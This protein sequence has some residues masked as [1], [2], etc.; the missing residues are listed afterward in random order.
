MIKAITEMIETVCEKYSGGGAILATI[1]IILF[2]IAWGFGMMCLRAWILM[3]LWNWVAVSLFGAPVLSFW[4]AF[5][6]SWLCSILFK[7]TTTTNKN[8]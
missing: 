3:L 6:L 4:L 7:S 1:G 2:A 8:S 5:G